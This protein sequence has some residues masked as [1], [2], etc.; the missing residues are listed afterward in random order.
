MLF[1]PFFVFLAFFDI[2]IVTGFTSCFSCV[3]SINTCY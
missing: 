2:F 1:S 3:L